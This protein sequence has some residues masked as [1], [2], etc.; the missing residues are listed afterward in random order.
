MG[1]ELLYMV[2]VSFG[3]LMVFIVVNFLDNLFN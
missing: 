3:P 1:N 2:G